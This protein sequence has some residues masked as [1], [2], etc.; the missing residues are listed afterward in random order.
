MT[1]TVHTRPSGCRSGRGCSWR[2]VL[3][4]RRDVDLAMRRHRTAGHDAS[5]RST[6]RVSGLAPGN[7]SQRQ[8]GA[9]VDH[10]DARGP[11]RAARS[12]ATRGVCGST[13][14]ADPSAIIGRH[15]QRGF[16]HFPRW[17]R[18]T[19]DRSF[20]PPVRQ[21]RKSGRYLFAG[22]TRARH[23]RSMTMVDEKTP[24]E[25][26]KLMRSGKPFSLT[27]A[28][29][30]ILE[31]ALAR[32]LGEKIAGDD[33]LP[34]LGRVSRT[35]FKPNEGSL[36]RRQNVPAGVVGE[37]DDDIEEILEGLR[38]QGNA[39][40]ADWLKPHLHSIKAGKGLVPSSRS[41]GEELAELRAMG[42]MHAMDSAAA[43]VPALMH[44]RHD[45]HGVAVRVPRGKPVSAATRTAAEKLA[46]AA[47]L[48]DIRIV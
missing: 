6:D 46:D 2:R 43:L 3:R 13:L 27:P 36:A 4:L 41:A 32:A 33:P 12:M 30:R 24:A 42:D 8:G 15:R 11:C 39:H 5:G 16:V 31:S 45:T 17:A 35:L 10:S 14:S 28:H 23:H 22:R 37:D 44:V 20:G 9:K 47:G 21:I 34:D 26:L 18:Q 48:R 7:H 19:W 40:I 38:G 1:V 25:L 29:Q